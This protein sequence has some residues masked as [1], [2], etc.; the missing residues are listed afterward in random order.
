MTREEFWRVA[1]ALKPGITR[2][3]YNRWWQE[4]VAMKAKRAALKSSLK[5][6]QGG[7]AD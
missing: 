1:R 5:V 3:Q 6:V 4:F 7:R 2:K